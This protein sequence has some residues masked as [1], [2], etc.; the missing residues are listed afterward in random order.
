[1]PEFDK[2]ISVTAA[3]LAALSIGLGAFGAHGLKNLVDANAIA[4][5]E[6]GV[7]YQMYHS[8][9]LLVLG[10]ASAV[11]MNTRKWVFRFF[12]LGILF[13]SGSIYLLSLSSVLPFSVSFLGPVTPVGGILLIIGWLR[14]AQGL[15][16]IRRG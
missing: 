3:I 5:F 9:A 12:I 4:T 7:R 2:K 13:F 14:L 6:T 10:F 15:L 1:M 8:I 16:T 11:P